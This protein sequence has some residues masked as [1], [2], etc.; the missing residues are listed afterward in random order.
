[1]NKTTTALGFGALVLALNGCRTEERLI[2]GT[3]T[4]GWSYVDSQLGKVA[5]MELQSELGPIHAYFKSPFG[6]NC[7]FFPIAA[8]FVNDASIRDKPVSIYGRFDGSGNLE[9]TRAYGFKK[10]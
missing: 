3:I 2:K 4:S 9:L 10:Q 7:E 6:S 5:T 1:M 8:T